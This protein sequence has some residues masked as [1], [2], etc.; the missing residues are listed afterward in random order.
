MSGIELALPKGRLLAGVE[1]RLNAAGLA[2]E[3]GHD[4]SDRCYA[5]KTNLPGVSGMIVKVRAI[6]QLLALG[7]FSLGFCGRDLIADSSHATD[8]VPLFDL[9]LNPVRIVVAVH[10]SQA[11][12]LDQ[13]PNRPLVIAT[14]YEGLAAVWA[15][16]RKLPAIIVNTYGSTEGYAPAKADI[17]FDCVETGDTMRANGLVIVEELLHSST[18]IVA[19]QSAAQRPEVRELAH[20]LAVVSVP[21]MAARQPPTAIRR[22]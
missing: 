22:G 3:R 12:V 20:R 17:V 21:P 8:L 15:L 1:A 10:E 9:G 7:S 18:W 13:R 14:E 5:V 2:L 16:N 19:G 6:P 4:G 11:T